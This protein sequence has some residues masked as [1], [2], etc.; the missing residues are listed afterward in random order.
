MSSNILLIIDN[1]I[2]AYD[3]SA[4]YRTADMYIDIFIE[5]GFDVKI[6]P[7]DFMRTEPYYSYYKSKSVEI[8]AGKEFKRGYKKWTK[9]HSGEIKYI[10]LNTPRAVSCINFFKKNTKAAII[11]H[12]RDMHFV[13]EYEHYRL[14]KSLKYLIRSKIFYFIEKYLY[15][16]SDAFASVSLKE[17]EDIKKINPRIQSYYFPVFYYKEQKAAENNFNRRAGL[18]FVGGNHSPNIDAVRWFADSV[19][20]LIKN[21]LPYV[22]LYVAGNLP[23][24]L[25]DEIKNRDII[26]TGT[27]ADEELNRLYRDAKLAVVPVR[28]GAGVKGKTIEAMHYNLPIVATSF[29][30]EGLPDI[31]K[32]IRPKD[33]AAEFADEVLRLYND[34]KALFDISRKAGEYAGEN[35]SREKAVSS[36]RNLLKL[37]P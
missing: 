15:K 17:C 2:P 34:D 27:I 37:R 8:L 31:E 36:I 1:S 7:L 18:L 30:L 25:K 29:A 21:E 20:P 19:F 26:F 9:K 4:G 33:T 12:G 13:R 11:Y 23:A 3:I 28:F 5:L 35:F 10:L 14:T 16:K 22:K 6:M 32:I 24:F